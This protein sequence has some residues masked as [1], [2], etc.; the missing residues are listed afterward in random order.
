MRM[1]PSNIKLYNPKISRDYTI[2]REES[3]TCSYKTANNPILRKKLKLKFS[4][5]L[6]DQ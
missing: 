4:K 3:R 2:S 5:I 6:E 1:V